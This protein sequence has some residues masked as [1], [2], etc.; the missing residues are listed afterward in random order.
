M[1]E[2]HGKKIIDWIDKFIKEEQGN[3]LSS[4]SCMSLK[5]I[6]TKEIDLIIQKNKEKIK[7][8]E[9]TKCIRPKI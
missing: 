1:T 3:K 7:D 4:F 8:D 5:A 2:E 6:I 9:T